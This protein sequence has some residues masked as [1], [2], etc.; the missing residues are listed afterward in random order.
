M[1]G[2]Q[3]PAGPTARR[4]HREEV[5]G[6]RDE[7]KPPRQDAERLEGLLNHNFEMDSGVKITLA[8]DG[9]SFAQAVLS[10]IH[11]NP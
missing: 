9:E 2:G 11:D 1:E 5:S 7:K 10:T 8:I 3:G 6:V 4:I